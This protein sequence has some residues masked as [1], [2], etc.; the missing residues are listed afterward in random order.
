LIF[1]IKG[2]ENTRK[3]KKKV[4]NVIN[5]YNFINF[6]KN[7]IEMGETLRIKWY[8]KGYVYFYQWII[9][10]FLYKLM[11]WTDLCTTYL[12]RIHSHRW[13][14]PTD[15]SSCAQY[16]ELFPLKNL[17]QLDHSRQSLKGWNT[18]RSTIHQVY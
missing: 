15:V 1:K 11:K 14:P 7:I 10:N 18:A 4:L 6:M 2:R 16:K 13:D 8:F 5:I 9:S 12:C 3:Q 17:L